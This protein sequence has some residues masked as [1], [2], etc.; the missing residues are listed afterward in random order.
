MIKNHSL[1]CCIVCGARL[2]VFL[3]DVDNKIN[4]GEAL[5]GRSNG[6]YNVTCNLL[7]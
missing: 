3:E 2:N 4:S 6:E 7:K 1:L 5:S